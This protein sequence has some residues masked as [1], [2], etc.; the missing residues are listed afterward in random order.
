MQIQFQTVPQ[1]KQKTNENQTHQKQSEWDRKQNK[2]AFLAESLWGQ[3][4]GWPGIFLAGINIDK[5]NPPH[6]TSCKTAKVTMV[7]KLASEQQL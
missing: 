6:A 4:E 7:C 1:Q 5:K 2:K 3:P